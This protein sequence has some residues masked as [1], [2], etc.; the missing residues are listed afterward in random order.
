MFNCQLN[1]LAFSILC[2]K[3]TIGLKVPPLASK[4]HQLWIVEHAVF[5]DQQL[6]RW[7]TVMGHWL[8]IGYGHHVKYT[9][10]SIPHRH[11]P[12][13]TSGNANINGN[14][15]SLIPHGTACSTHVH[16]VT[17]AMATPYLYEVE[18]PI[19]RI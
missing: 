11:T 2:I 13:D 19:V 4:V 6:R 5:F 14:M 3:P 10:H 7:Y 18:H 15:Q 12:H 16:G 8:A 17:V 9:S 1:S